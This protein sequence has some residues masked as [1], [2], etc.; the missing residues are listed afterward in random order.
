[1][2]IA[3]QKLER[4]IAGMNQEEFNHNEMA[5]SAVLREFQVIGEAARLI[6]DETKAQRDSVAVCVWNAKPG[7]SR[8][9]QYRPGYCVGYDSR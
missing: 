2:L 9:F 4:F 5:Q 8:V 7:Y 3:A 1:M 6:S